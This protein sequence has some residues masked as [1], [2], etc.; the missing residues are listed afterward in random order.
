MAVEEIDM[1]VPVS[2]W[3]EP[4]AIPDLS[5]APP[6]QAAP[7]SSIVDQVRAAVVRRRRFAVGARQRRRRWGEFDQRLR[8]LVKR[9]AADA[10]QHVDD[11][12][13]RGD[14]RVQVYAAMAGLIGVLVADHRATQRRAG[15]RLK[16]CAGLVFLGCCALVGV[17][18]ATGVLAL[19]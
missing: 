5:G 11:R 10:T 2:G 9:A 4:A 16:M 6:A 3:Q 14:V 15:F 18:L 1:A 8:V 7:R 19:A 12:Q 13:V 17:L